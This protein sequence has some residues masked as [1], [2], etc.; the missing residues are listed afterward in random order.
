MAKKVLGLLFPVSGNRSHHVKRT[1][2]ANNS[3][4]I[5]RKSNFI[6]RLRTDVSPILNSVLP[7]PVYLPLPPCLVQR[8]SC[9]QACCFAPNSDMIKNK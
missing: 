3:H 1:N 9:L 2:V 8:L 4:R 5:L 7:F 6:N